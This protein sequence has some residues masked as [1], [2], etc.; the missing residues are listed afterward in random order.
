[1][2]A[3]AARRIGARPLSVAPGIPV[4]L[5]QPVLAFDDRTFSYGHAV[6]AAVVSGRWPHFVRRVGGAGRDDPD[7]WWSH[8]L[9]GGDLAR[10]LDDLVR[11]SAASEVEA[12]TGGPPR[13]GPLDPRLVEHALRSPAAV[14]FPNG[15]MAVAVAEVT[16]LRDAHRRVAASVAGDRDLLASCLRERTQAWTRLTY[17]QLTVPEG[18]GPVAS[19]RGA[20]LVT[21]HERWQEDCPRELVTLLEGLEPGGL[22]GPLGAEGPAHLF[23]LVDRRRPTLA[24]PEVRRRAAARALGHRLDRAAAG[25]ARWLV[26]S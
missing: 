9:G 3:R 23:V 22:A 17:D 13:D 2:T 24:Q 8:A 18:V 6:L 26:P 10:W 4:D 11:G 5:A 25:R 14:A 16:A 21:R 1:M 7:R 12:A 15:R 20:G 19:A